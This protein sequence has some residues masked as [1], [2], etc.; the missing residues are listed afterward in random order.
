MVRGWKHSIRRRAA[1]LA[2]LEGRSDTRGGMRRVVRRSQAGNV[3]RLRIQLIEL[4]T[5]FERQLMDGDLRSRVLALI[6][7]QHL[8]RD[9]GGSLI[10]PDVADS[11][12]DRILHYFRTLS[13]HRHL[14]ATS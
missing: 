11:R 9:L 6:P 3:E 7:A 4:L 13:A 5:E 8:L 2:R 1:L 10:P 14:R 12:R